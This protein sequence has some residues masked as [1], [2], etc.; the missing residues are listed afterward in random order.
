MYTIQTVGLDEAQPGQMIAKRVSSN[1]QYADD[2]TL[3]T[4][5]KEKPKSHLMKLKEEHEE[6][7]IKSKFK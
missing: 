1:L 3:R 4:E 7:C 5:S 6:A 2:S